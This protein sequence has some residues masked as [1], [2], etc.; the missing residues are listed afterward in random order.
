[1]EFLITLNLKLMEPTRARVTRHERF[2]LDHIMVNEAEQ[3][4]LNCKIV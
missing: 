1:M 2:S 3:L 4:I